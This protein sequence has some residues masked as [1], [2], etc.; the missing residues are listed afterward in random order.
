[1]PVAQITIRMNSEGAEATNREI[2]NVA[3]SIDTV[4]SATLDV[5]KNSVT[6]FRA[7][8]KEVLALVGAY[9]TLESAMDFARRGVNQSAEWEQS[10]IGIAS[11]LASVRE[12]RDEQGNLVKG[13]AA[14]Q[15]ALG[16]AEEAMQKIKI[17]GLETTATSQDLVAGFQQLIGPAAALGNELGFRLGGSFGVCGHGLSPPGLNAPCTA[18]ARY[19]RQIGPQ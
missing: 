13:A 4:N 14:Y 17:L 16:M 7:A 3:A 19:N 12:V 5:S 9:K 11:V 2:K 8:A 10:K 1:M 15:Q 18:A 6:A